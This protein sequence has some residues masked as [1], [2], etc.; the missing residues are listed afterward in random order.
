MTQNRTKYAILGILALA[1]QTGYE[2]KQ[3]IERSLSA[4]WQESYGQLYPT[5][6]LLVSEGLAIM[7]EERVVRADKLRADK[8]KKPLDSTNTT[9][10]AQDAEAQHHA[11]N[12]HQNEHQNEYQEPLLG[13]K[14][15]KRYTITRKG[16]DELTDWLR[17]TALQLPVY[18]N[19]LLLKL[20]F[21]SHLRK[22][23]HIVR[24]RSYRNELANTKLLLEATQAALE[25]G[26]HS[27]S[28]VAYQY[29]A[30]QHG[31]YAVEAELRW[32][33]ES[34]TFLL[35]AIHIT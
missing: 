14:L 2:L 16:R 30:V 35:D 27:R 22:E 23:H 26:K 31:L 17:D 29:L 19:E 4:F 20:F 6:K 13:G 28:D 1:P 15:K 32:V 24:L 12:E 18:R 9:A 25:T 33:E 10:T 5:L 21:G 11:P 3:F 7:D 8:R 34:I